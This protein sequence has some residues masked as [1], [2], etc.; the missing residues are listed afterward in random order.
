MLKIAVGMGPQGIFYKF[1]LGSRVIL[2]VIMKPADHPHAP[3]VSE[4]K[5]SRK[6]KRS[7]T[8]RNE[9]KRKEKKRKPQLPQKRKQNKQNTKH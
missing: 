5:L 3:D 8:K 9:T 1:K 7:E 4:L 2:L 6:E